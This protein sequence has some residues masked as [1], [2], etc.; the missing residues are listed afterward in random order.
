[1]GNESGRRPVR[2]DPPLREWV[3][4]NLRYIIL[5][6]V[7]AAV[8]IALFFILGVF[9]IGTDGPETA[10]SA[11]SAALETEEGTRIQEKDSEQSAASSGKV[12][13]TV[14]PAPTQTVTPAPTKAEEKPQTDLVKAQKSV[15][16]IIGAY[17]GALGSADTEGAEAVTESISESDRIAIA[18][19]AYM[20]DYSDIKVWTYPGENADEYVAFVSYS[21][22]YPGYGTRI[23][24][25]TVLYIVKGED[26]SP[27]IASEETEARKSQ[28]I[29]AALET[30]EVK[31][32]RSEISGLYDEAL[33]SDP[34]L[35]EYMASLG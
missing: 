19:G 21:Y 2:Q 35:A 1:M 5:I 6:A 34:A 9:K 28:S 29:D 8:V 12:K 10:S 27:L 14:T 11:E 13:T 23:P 33:A 31:E 26:G 30:T 22:T 25:L 32:L 17:F 24:A 20:R 3:S 7:I 18:D 15:S 16:D 4:D